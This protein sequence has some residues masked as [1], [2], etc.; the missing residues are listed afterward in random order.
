[1]E[2]LAV[3]SFLVG[4]WA[5]LAKWIRPKPTSFFTR[6]SALDVVQ[7]FREEWDLARVRNRR[8]DLAVLMDRGFETMR[9]YEPEMRKMQVWTSRAATREV[10]ALGE[11][12]RIYANQIA[13][14]QV[15][16][17][18]WPEMTGN[19]GRQLG[20]TLCALKPPKKH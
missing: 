20:Q 19:I 8:V 17:G 6:N 1:M 10:R 15:D 13:R 16:S 7:R 12:C 2:I 18:D 5:L 14:N 4:V 3:A 9:R 11:M